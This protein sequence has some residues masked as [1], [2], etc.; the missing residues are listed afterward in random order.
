MSWSTGASASA[1]HPAVI[2]NRIVRPGTPW[3]SRGSASA[4]MGTGRAVIVPPTCTVIPIERMA[5]A[6]PT[7]A[8]V[9]IRAE[10]FQP[11]T[12]APTSSAISGIPR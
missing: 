7:R 5:T 8:Q 4:S 10:V 1:A 12:T 6:K 2:V 11:L 3:R 9:R